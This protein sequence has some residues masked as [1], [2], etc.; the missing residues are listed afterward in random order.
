PP[1]QAPADLPVFAQAAMR[2]RFGGDMELEQVALESF[3][4]T[5]PALLAKLQAALEQGQRAQA[6]MLAHSAKG[7][8]SMI[9]AQRYAG[10]AA[11]L[12][13]RGPSAP[14]EELL[15]LL[16]QLRVA[17]REFVGV[18]EGLRGT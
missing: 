1:S 6:T 11:T 13:E 14:I 3:Q 8:G 10:I 2:E 12:E 17:F 4:Q 9:C 7:A 5:T 18:L 16:A 15:T